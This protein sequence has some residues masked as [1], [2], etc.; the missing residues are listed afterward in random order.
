MNFV[1]MIRLLFNRGVAKGRSL[2]AIKYACVAYFPVH[3]ISLRFVDTIGYIILGKWT[4]LFKI[5]IIGHFF[6]K[7]DTWT[8]N[9]NKGK[10]PVLDGLDHD[11]FH[12]MGIT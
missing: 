6:V 7:Y 10:S 3:G 1:I 2:P 4:S 11:I 5:Q 9:M 8:E 12:L